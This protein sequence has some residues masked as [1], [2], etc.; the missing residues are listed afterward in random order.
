MH[1]RKGDEVVVIAG[2]EAGRRGRVLRVEPAR[3][4]VVVEGV[5]LHTK[6][7]KKTPANPK[8]GQVDREMSIAAS[9]VMLWSEQAGK[10]VRTRAVIEGG[11]KTRVGIPCGT[12]FVE[13]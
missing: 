11:K 5:N 9:N 7:L 2:N 1:L 8:G 12:K 6:N 3:G 13:R 10:G 4:R